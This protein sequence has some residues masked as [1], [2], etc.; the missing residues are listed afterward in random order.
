MTPTSKQIGLLQHTIGVSEWQ[1]EPHRNHFVAGPGHHDQKDL[2]QLEAA[3]LM[4]R[5]RTPSFIPADS[6][7]FM[8]TEAGRALAIAS[9]PEPKKPTRYE[10]Y[11]RADGCAGDSFGE[12]L[13]GIRLPEFE[14]RRAHNRPRGRWGYECY[15]Y[16]M[17]RCAGWD[18]YYGIPGGR[19]VQGDWAPTKKEAKAS[20]KAALKAHQQARRGDAL[21][22]AA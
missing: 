2:E 17:F 7:V 4:G 11:L 14:S 9:L 3:G 13:C 10:E 12:F 16:R 21:R 5:G 8:V 1:R 15:E 20:Y 6:V 19:D 22:K 18:S